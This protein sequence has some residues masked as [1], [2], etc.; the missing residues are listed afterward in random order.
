MSYG[1]S[2]PIDLGG[3]NGEGA[4]AQG[5]VLTDEVPPRPF[6][7]GLAISVLLLQIQRLCVGVVVEELPKRCFSFSDGRKHDA[8]PVSGAM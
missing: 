1:V 2:E 6:C 3:F 8:V 7:P 5:W 4:S